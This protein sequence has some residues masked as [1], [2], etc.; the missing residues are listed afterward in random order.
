MIDLPGMEEGREGIY[1]SQMTLGKGI[2]MLLSKT[3]NCGKF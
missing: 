2:S 1:V 3:L